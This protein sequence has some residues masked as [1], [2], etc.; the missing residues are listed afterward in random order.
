MYLL[1]LGDK[2]ID[3]D[4]L[5]ARTQSLGPFIEYV[6]L[7]KQSQD[8]LRKRARFTWE[9]VED[10]KRIKVTKREAIDIR[11]RRFHLPYCLE[12]DDDTEISP[13]TKLMNLK[14]G[15]TTS[16]R[17]VRKTPFGLEF[18]TERDLSE[19]EGWLI[20]DETQLLSCGNQISSK[21]NSKRS[22]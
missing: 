20:F 14:K 6:E 4:A 18:S 10:Q 7:S 12:E 13:G 15:I 17:T 9:I 21:K 22:H 1:A 16:V 8:H 2:G 11:V 5:D 3:M 19:R